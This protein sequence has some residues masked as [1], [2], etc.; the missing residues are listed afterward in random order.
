MSASAK[1]WT[2]LTNHGHVLV[3]LAVDPNARLRDIAD[4]V[5]ITERAVQQIVT[6]LEHEGYVIKER[7]GRR[8][9]YAVVRDGKFR[10]PMEAGMTVGAFLDLVLAA[11]SR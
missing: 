9:Q 10:H 1:G 8:N 4:R 7:V 3:C 2:F 5:G 11:S 6:E